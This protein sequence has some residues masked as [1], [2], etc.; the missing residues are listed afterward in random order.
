VA[1]SKEKAN[2]FLLERPAYAADLDFF[3][4]NDLTDVHAFDDAVKGIDGVIH[5]AS[6]SIYSSSTHYRLVADIRLQ[7]R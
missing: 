2:A 3:Y 1:R 4:I 7:S 5:I 6:V